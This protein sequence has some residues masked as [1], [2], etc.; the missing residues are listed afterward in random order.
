MHYVGNHFAII[1]SFPVCIR[2]VTMSK[3]HPGNIVIK[4]T[5]TSR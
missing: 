1:Q 3:N 2:A 5:S 4:T